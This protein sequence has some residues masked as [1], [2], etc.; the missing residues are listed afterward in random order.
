[1]A[2]CCIITPKSYI[3]L[4]ERTLGTGILNLGPNAQLAPNISLLLDGTIEWNYTKPQT[5][6]MVHYITAGIT[7]AACVAYFA[8]GP[9]LSQV[10]IQAKFTRPRSR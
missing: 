10:L 2:V 1:M 3:I 9:S 6:C 5:H 8:L 7:A 4:E